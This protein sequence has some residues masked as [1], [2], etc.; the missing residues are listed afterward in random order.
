M[1]NYL[2]W[3]NQR[4]AW[5]RPGGA[6][7]TL[8]IEEAGRYWE[9]PARQIISDSTVGG[10]LVF[11]RTDPVTGERY[12]SYDEV[13][14]LSPESAAEQAREL[15]EARRELGLLRMH[16]CGGEGANVDP[17][18]QILEHQGLLLRVIPMDQHDR[19]C[20]VRVASAQGTTPEVLHCA[21]CGFCYP[22]ADATAAA[23]RP[24]TE[25]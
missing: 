15:E 1:S 14:V 8:A 13:L 10:Q 2:I 19:R 3:S 18:V 17:E 5:W 20:R 24:A 12:Q 7:Y 22:K 25:A 21:F 6:G 16:A 11:T 23:A 4:Q 9:A